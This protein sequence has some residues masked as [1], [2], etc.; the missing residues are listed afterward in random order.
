MV[1]KAIP[2]RPLQLPAKAIAGVAAIAAALFAQTCKADPIPKGWQASGLEVVG[3]TGLEGRAGAFKLA[4]KHARNG[5]WYLYAGHSFHQ[6]WSIID[7]TDPKKPRYVKFI[8]YQT[9][10]K[11]V[12]TAQVT[13]HDD[14]MITAIDKKS[15]ADPTLLIWDISDPENPKKIGQWKGAVGGSHRNS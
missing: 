8:P 3:F 2:T 6:G 12:L 4:V 13:L 15:K 7:V 9:P 5:H 10:T 14:I 11:E 1:F